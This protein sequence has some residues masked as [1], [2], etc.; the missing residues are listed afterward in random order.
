[1]IALA[2]LLVG[3]PFIALFA[4]CWAIASRDN[5]LDLPGAME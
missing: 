4:L 2:L 1:M 5:A 3:L